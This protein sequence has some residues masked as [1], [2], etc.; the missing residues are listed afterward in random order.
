M[1]PNGWLQFAI[2]SVILLALVRP[3][4][5][6]LARVVEGE[7]TWLDPVLRPCERLIY[8][9]CAVNAEKE[10]NWRQYAFA[11]L[12]FSAVTM[13][14][15]YAIERLQQY[16]PFNPQ[17]FPAV[18]PDLAFNTA[19]SFTTNTNWQF[20]SGRIHDELSDPDDGPGDA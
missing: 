12:G 4:G 3:V 6:Y 13:V 2:Y 10:M 17:H 16:L 1:T 14:F 9:L 19:A 8:K 20:Y 15:T 11:L 5:I 18:G 7:R